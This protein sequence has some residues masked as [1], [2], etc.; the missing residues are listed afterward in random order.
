M[1]TSQDMYERVVE[2]VNEHEDISPHNKK[3]IVD[4][5]KSRQTKR[6]EVF[7]ASGTY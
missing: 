3:K 6:A 1:G 4:F 7:R 5:L 2:K